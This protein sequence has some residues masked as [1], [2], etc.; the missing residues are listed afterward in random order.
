MSKIDRLVRAYGDQVR[1]PWAAHASGPERTWFVVYDPDDERRLRNQ[2]QAF[3]IATR[4]AGHGWRKQDLTGAFAEWLAQE[5][6]REAY[7]GDP[8]TLEASLT[9]D[10]AELAAAKVRAV[11]GVPDV[12]AETVVAIYG[13][14]ALFGLIRVAD[15]VSAVLPA[16][17]GRLAVF[18]PGVHEGGTYRHLAATDGWNYLA[19]PITANEG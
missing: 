19:V 18:F 11:A 13:T 15:L 16:V 12:D 8:E 14:A 6:Y 2:L 10:F 1:L 4:E 9:E 17:R 3:E 5:E 7:F